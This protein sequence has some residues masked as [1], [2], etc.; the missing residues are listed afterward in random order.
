M[1]GLTTGEE[2]RLLAGGADEATGAGS[3]LGYAAYAD[4]CLCRRTTRT[5]LCREHVAQAGRAPTRSVM[6]PARTPDE[7]RP[8]VPPAPRSPSSP[9]P[10]PPT[11]TGPGPAAA[12]PPPAGPSRLSWAAAG[13][14]QG[15]VNGARGT[16][17]GGARAGRAGT[18]DC[19][20]RGLVRY[21]GGSSAAGG[22]LPSAFL[23]KQGAVGTER[24]APG[25]PPQ[26]RRLGLPAN[27]PTE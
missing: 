25:P 14:S 16:C 7:A 21:S 1:R 23:E 10:R 18:C 13:D 26:G 8:Q 5:V 12:P 11:A 9:S 17:G 20:D 3:A 2:Y 27:V 22:A 4:F 24:R 6:P 19:C 15:W